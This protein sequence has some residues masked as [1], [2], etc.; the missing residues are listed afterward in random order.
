MIDM[1]T[2]TRVARTKGI[3]N[4]GNAEKDYFQDL[5]LLAVSRESPGLVFKGGT[6]LFKLHGLDRFSEDLDFTG[7]LTRPEVLRLARYVGDFG[8]PADAT[9]REAGGACLRHMA[10]RASF[11]RAP[12]RAWRGYG[13]MRAGRMRFP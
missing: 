1:Q 4:L 10:S 13:S 3:A 6:A 2:L 8:Y 5:L 11:T 9:V 7:R 12:R